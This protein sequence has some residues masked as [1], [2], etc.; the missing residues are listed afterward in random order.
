MP[1]SF[2]LYDNNGKRVQKGYLSA[3]NN[4]LQLPNEKG[5]YL[6]VIQEG[7]NKKLVKLVRK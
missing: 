6:L 2:D 5:T 7:K 4:M 1:A 3:V